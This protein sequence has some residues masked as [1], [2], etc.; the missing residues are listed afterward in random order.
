MNK[1]ILSKLEGKKLT[2]VFC[3]MKSGL[4]FGISERDNQDVLIAKG[5]WEETY[6]LETNYNFDFDN[7]AVAFFKDW[8]TAKMEQTSI[9]LVKDK[10]SAISPKDWKRL[11]KPGKETSKQ[12]ELK[13][14]L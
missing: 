4:V 8:T 13:V 1:N 10:H 14:K 6:Y 3:E 2:W 11:K 7:S 9:I 5:K 12:L